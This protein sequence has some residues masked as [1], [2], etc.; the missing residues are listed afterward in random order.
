MHKRVISQAKNTALGTG[1]SGGAG[2]LKS[3]CAVRW[4]ASLSG[5]D[6]RRQN[7]SGAAAPE[8]LFGSEKSLVRFDMWS[9]WKKHS[10][11]K[12]IGA[13]QDSRLR[14][15]RSIDGTCAAKDSVLRI[16]PRRNRKRRTRM[17]Q[18]LLQ[19]FEDGN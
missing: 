12:L 3:L 1:N 2:G 4:D 13:P 17:S 15:R 9:L 10:V 16:W 14:K 18:Y 19:V 8:F 6:G 5:A 11:S 7:G